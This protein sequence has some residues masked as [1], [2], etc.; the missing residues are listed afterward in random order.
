MWGSEIIS[1]SSREIRRSDRRSMINN[2]MLIALCRRLLFAL[3][4]GGGKD[5]ILKTKNQT[6]LVTMYRQMVKTVIY[7]KTFRHVI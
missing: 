7:G 5:K 6:V 4:R 3:S 2:G 1:E